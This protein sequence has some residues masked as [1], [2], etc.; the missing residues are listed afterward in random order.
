MSKKESGPKSFGFGPGSRASTYPLKMGGVLGL[1]PSKEVKWEKLPKGWDD[2]SLNKFHKSIG[3]E[4]QE[5][6]VSTC[7]KK[8][9]SH[10]DDPGAFCAALHDKVTGTTKWR[11]KKETSP[12]GLV[13]QFG[14][15]KKAHE[16]DGSAGNVQVLRGQK[17]ADE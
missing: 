17:N 5:G 1:K 2:Q 8:I 7:I 16:A 6:T 12:L 14:S 13:S 4:T 9:G 10:V 11:G 15:K 3:T